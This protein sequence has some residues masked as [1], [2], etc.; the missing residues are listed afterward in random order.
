LENLCTIAVSLTDHHLP[1]VVISK[2][3]SWCTTLTTN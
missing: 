1:Q 3:T 2:L